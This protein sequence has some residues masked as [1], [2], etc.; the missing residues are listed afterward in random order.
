MLLY[1]LFATTWSVR[2]EAGFVPWHPK[3]QLE[4]TLPKKFN[5]K[6]NKKNLLKH[7]KSYFCIPI[8]ISVNVRSTIFPVVPHRLSAAILC[9][10]RFPTKLNTLASEA[11]FQTPYHTSSVNYCLNLFSC[12]TCSLAVISVHTENK[13]T[14]KLSQL[15]KA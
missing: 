11:H 14:E 4:P 1:L 7:P 6:K 13:C 2:W 10:T 12:L 8:T 3:I 9:V 5:W 15:V